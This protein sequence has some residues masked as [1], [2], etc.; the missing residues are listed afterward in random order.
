MTGYG[1]SAS[2]GA[3]PVI[4]NHQIRSDSV[5]LHNDFSLFAGLSLQHSFS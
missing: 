1:M 2:T 3:A 4:Q 5:G